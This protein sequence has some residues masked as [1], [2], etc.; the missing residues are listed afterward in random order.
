MPRRPSVSNATHDWGVL[1]A[2]QTHGIHAVG[3]TVLLQFAVRFGFILPANAPQNM[4]A[5]GTDTFDS[6]DFIRTERANTLVAGVLL[7]IFALWYWPWMGFRLEE[8]RAT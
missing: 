3:M 5:H 7:V 1:S 2:V 8:R 4:I 6:R